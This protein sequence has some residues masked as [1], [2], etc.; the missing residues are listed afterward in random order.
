MKLHCI[1]NLRNDNLYLVFGIIIYTVYDS[2]CFTII[3]NYSNKF[4]YK[5]YWF[6]V[7]FYKYKANKINYS[8]V[9]FHK[10][11]LNKIKWTHLINNINKDN[12]S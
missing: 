6:C 11:Q 1:N 9:T 4:D 12:K 7:L 5:H 8:V 3:I 2:I 10:E